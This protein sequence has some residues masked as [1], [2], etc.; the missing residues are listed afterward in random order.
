MYKTVLQQIANSLYV[1]IQYINNTGLLSGITGCSLF[2]YKYARY[3]NHTLYSDLADEL[4]EILYD[5]LTQELPLNFANGLSGIAWGIHHMAAGQ[6]IEIEE[7]ALEEIEA[8]IYDMKT[9]Q[10]ETDLQTDLPLF[11]KG[12]YALH[13]SGEKERLSRIIT[14]S[15]QFLTTYADPNIALSYLNS[16][17][18]FILGCQ[19]LQIKHPSLTD[20]TDL[21]Y[22][23]IL[24]SIKRNPY[25]EEEKKHLQ[26]FIPLLLAPDNLVTEKEKWEQ[27]LK[28]LRTEPLIQTDFSFTW[29]DLLSGTNE[30]LNFAPGKESVPD[31]NNYIENKIRHLT[32][33]NLGIQNGL[34]GIGYWLMTKDS[35]N[36]SSEN[37]D[38]P[39]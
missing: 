9:G 20:L 35:R 2:L 4:I 33:K 5:K 7:N 10:F 17:I 29:L 18:Y 32:P 21:L 6:Y 36:Y 39:S 27:L 22:N 11:S 12:L 3:S 31:I 26:H 14:E 24:V 28:Q 34:T 16:V 23:R 19:K 25:I 37:P 38:R 13:L 1:N 8:L 15:V 30:L